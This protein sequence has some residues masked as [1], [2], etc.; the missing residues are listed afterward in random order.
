MRWSGRDARSRIHARDWPQLEK[1]SYLLRPFFTAFCVLFSFSASIAKLAKRCELQVIDLDHK[2]Q[3]QK[4]P[5]ADPAGGDEAGSSR[6]IKRLITP[7]PRY[8]RT[9]VARRPPAPERKRRPRNREEAQQKQKGGANPQN[10]SVAMS[11]V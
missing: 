2:D 7:Y 10:F 11:G 9:L 6:S 4:G 5:L 1:I 8:N 3:R